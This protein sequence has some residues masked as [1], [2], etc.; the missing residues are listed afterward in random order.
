MTTT[1]DPADDGLTWD[2]PDGVLEVEPAPDVVP[3]KL[4]DAVYW[5]ALAVAALGLLAVGQVEVWAPQYAD[6]ITESWD[7]IDNWVLFVTGA[8]GVAYRPTRR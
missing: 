4:R 2:T 7:R 8:L 1:P 3:P 6:R 5:T